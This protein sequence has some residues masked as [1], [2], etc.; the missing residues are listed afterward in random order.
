GGAVDGLQ[1]GAAVAIDRDAADFDRQSSDKGGHA[2]DVVAL[3]ALLLDATPLNIL[4]RRGRHADAI[5][6]RTHQIRREIIG[7]DIA[8]NALLRM[9]AANGRADGI[10]DNSM[11]HETPP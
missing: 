3:F 1:T 11:A 8:V 7:A 5:E 2:R 6:Q 4:N 10:N 9:S